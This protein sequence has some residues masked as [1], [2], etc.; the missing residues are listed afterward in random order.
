MKRLAIVALVL[1]GFVFPFV[2]SADIPVDPGQSGRIIFSGRQPMTLQ[3]KKDFEPFNRSSALT[4][5]GKYILL[6]S[7][8]NDLI[9]FD[10]KTGDM[11]WKRQ[12]PEF[13][14][15]APGIT[16][17]VGI[18]GSVNGNISVYDLERGET[19][20]NITTGWDEM[21]SP[22]SGECNVFIKGLNHKLKTA[23]VLCIDLSKGKVVGRQVPCGYIDQPPV[24]DGQHFF[25]VSKDL[26]SVECYTQDTLTRV[27]NKNL[28]ENVKYLSTRFNLLVATC[29]SG[30]VVVL[31]KDSGE[32]INKMSFAPPI[33]WP[34]SIFQDRIVVCSEDGPKLSTMSIETGEILWQ[35]HFVGIVGQPFVTRDKIVVTDGKKVQFLDAQ[36]GNLNWVVELPSVA[37]GMPLP[38]FDQIFVATSL[39]KLISFRSA[40]F[41]IETSTHKVNFGTVPE[42]TPEIFE[43][44]VVHNMSAEPQTIRTKSNAPWLSVSNDGFEIA[45]FDFLQVKLF[46]NLND[47]QYGDHTAKVE[48]EWKYGASVVE[49][50]LKKATPDQAKPFAPPFLEVATS[51]LSLAGC[52]NMGIPSEPVTIFNKGETE[53]TYSVS[54]NRPWILLG[55]SEG[56]VHG[57]SSNYF[58]V[59]VLTDLTEVGENFGEIKVASKESGQIFKIFVKFTRGLGRVHVVS[60]LKPESTVAYIGSVKVRIR[61]APFYNEE[62]L[63][64]VPLDFLK[65]AVEASIDQFDYSDG[66]SLFILKRGH[67]TMSHRVGENVL[68]VQNSDEYREVE[69]ACP[70]V[71]VDGRPMFPIETI[72]KALGAK[73]LFDPETERVTLDAFLPELP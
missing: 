5:N 10:A 33:P 22:S 50:V 65:L 13:S 16:A 37:V 14:S 55:R 43:H 15:R 36:G 11:L 32:F 1:L 18:V 68:L 57:K 30:N 67:L 28:G 63:L 40:G 58:S 23:G 24:L 29:D 26:K 48:I 34:V 46:A 35:N 69:L 4:T 25:V 41:E 64:M 53:A 12:T 44:V 73:I 54:S 2:E 8:Y 47:L 61:P 20:F 31:E 56:Q 45:P 66:P 27:W 7:G 38:V 6:V 21:T 59:V 3:W 62:G 51:K 9:C 52:L 49:V 17:L 72:A 39:K 71:I 60:M 19:K 70:S 42:K